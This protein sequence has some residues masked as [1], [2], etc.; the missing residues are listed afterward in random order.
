MVAG[1]PIAHTFQHFSSRGPRS[2]ARPGRRDIPARRPLSRR[3][4]P[5]RSRGSSYEWPLLAGPSRSAGQDVCS[6]GPPCAP[7]SPPPHGPSWRWAEPG[8]GLRSPS[9]ESQSWA[10]LPLGPGSGCAR[11]LGLSR[12][13]KGRMVCG[14]MTLCGHEDQGPTHRATPQVRAAPQGSPGP[15]RAPPEP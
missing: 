10:G 5:G 15:W 11:T 4:A 6:A 3:L 12:D 9:S 7:A 1:D 14:E 13:V 8:K 2:T